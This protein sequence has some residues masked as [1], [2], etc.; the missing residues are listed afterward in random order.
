MPLFVCSKCNCIENTAL[1]GFWFR[2]PGDNKPL[3]SECDPAFK[4]GWHG[5]FPKEKF[6]PE[7]WEYEGGKFKKSSWNFIKRKD[8]KTKA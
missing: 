6:D 7:I 8:E 3:C 1:S 4:I 2:D 5:R